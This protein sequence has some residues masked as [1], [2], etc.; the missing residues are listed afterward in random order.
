MAVTVTENAATQ[1]ARQLERR[2][3]GVGLRLSVK[4]AG[5]SGYAY[6]VDYAEEITADDSVFEQH[7]VKIVVKTTD[8]A[9]LDGVEVDYAREGLNDAF[10]FHNPK[11]TASCGCGESF[12]V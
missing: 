4:Q 12:A 1:I 7:G 6:V 11:A 10:R 8:L 3:R 5:C 2:G 9:Y